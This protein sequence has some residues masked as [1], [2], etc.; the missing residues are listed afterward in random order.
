MTHMV[1]RIKTVYSFNSQSDSRQARTPARFFDGRMPSRL[2]IFA[3]MGIGW[4]TACFVLSGC[5][6]AQTTIEP[7]QTAST[8]DNPEGVF[9]QE[10]Q[11]K[12]GAQV[13]AQNC[14][15]CHNLRRPRERSD[16]EWDIIVHHMRV[17]GNLTAEEHRL[18]REFLRSAN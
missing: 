12:G 15:R 17:R 2:S 9:E 13:W 18:I 11:V 14:M 7:S 3:I 4:L 16:R 6:E 1:M 5:H 8:Q 10:T